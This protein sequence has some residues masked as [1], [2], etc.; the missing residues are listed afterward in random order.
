MQKMRPRAR[1][2]LHPHGDAYRAMSVKVWSWVSTPS[3]AAAA[4]AADLSAVCVCVCVGRLRSATA[5]LRTAREPPSDVRAS[6][7]VTDRDAIRRE[8]EN[9]HTHTLDLSSKHRTRYQLADC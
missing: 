7:H 3:P 8:E 5:D 4:A 9:T 1:A 2:Y 6:L